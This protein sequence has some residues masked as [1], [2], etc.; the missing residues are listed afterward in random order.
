MEDLEKEDGQGL[1]I[2]SDRQKGLLEA[3]NGVTPK[4]EIRFCARHIWANFK[5]QWPG[6]LFKEAFWKAARSTSQAEFISEMKGIQFLNQAAYEYLAAIPP[7]HWSR[8][9]F[10]TTSKSNMLLNNM[11]ESFNAVLKPARDKPIISLMEWIRRY[12]MKRH[13]DKRMGGEGYKSKVMPFVNEYLK[14]VENEARFCCLIPSF[15]GEFEVDHRGKQKAVNLTRR[16]CS[17]KS[18][19]LTGIPCPHA[20]FCIRD[21][22]QEVIDY[23]DECYSKTTY[24]K[25]FQHPIVA[26]PGHED[27]EKVDMAAPTPP[28]FKKLPGRPKLKK[29]R[30]EVGEGSN[31]QTKKL[32]QTRTCGRCGG[33]G[34]NK[35]TC[36]NPPKTQAKEKVAATRGMSTSAWSKK[37]REGA[38]K[39][40]AKKA[41]DAAMVE[42]ISGQHQ[43][44]QETHYA[45]VNNASPATVSR[46]RAWF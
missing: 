7:K 44:V 6:G 42:Q 11:C 28:P 15:S 37:V 40:K 9:A 46:R 26:M 16:T 14:W 38:A 36:K 17:C 18:W 25:A 35:K 27:W 4:A 1:T 29:R 10:S 43:S 31:G 8:H 21:Q 23:V 12:V 2:M 39:R 32:R 5:L 24:I 19:D 30:R 13:Y 22:R 3:F 20:M 34:H 45:S 33:N 41:Q